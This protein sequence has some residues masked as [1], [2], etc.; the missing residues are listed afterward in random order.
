MGRNTSSWPGCSGLCSVC[1]PWPP[2][3]QQLM[4]TQSLPQD[5]A[6]PGDPAHGTL[7]TQPEMQWKQGRADVFKLDMSRLEILSPPLSSAAWFVLGHH[8]NSQPRSEAQ[9][10]GSEEW[11]K[12]QPPPSTL[13]TVVSSYPQGLSRNTIFSHLAFLEKSARDVWSTSSACSV[14]PHARLLLLI[15]LLPKKGSP[16]SLGP[17]MWEY[18]QLSV[19]C[20]FVCFLEDLFP[21]Q[22]NQSL[23]EHSIYVLA[24]NNPQLR[25]SIRTTHV[26]VKKY[27]LL[28][29]CRWYWTISFG[30][31]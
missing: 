3:T 23:S 22:L 4:T 1:L 6:P 27:P 14:S 9:P 15:Q 13:A 31:T 12:Q 2:V 10:H 26:G 8:W 19:I 7:C 11:F 21:H 20:L 18:I 16:K 28:L 29:I 25:V 30:A 5:V 17:S 24:S